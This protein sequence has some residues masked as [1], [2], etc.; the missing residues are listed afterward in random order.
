LTIKVKF[1]AYF[2]DLFGE[3]EKEVRLLEGSRLRD[4]LKA[5]CD[6]A[7]REKQIFAEEEKLNPHTVIMKNGMPVQSSGGL[8]APLADGDI[9][10][11]FPYL[12]GG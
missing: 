7:E 4:L 10:A 11:I 12:G 8:A 9:I 1:L 2:R 6:T 5:L 3:R